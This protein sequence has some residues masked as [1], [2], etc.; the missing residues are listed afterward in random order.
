MKEG[1][2]A[3]KPSCFSEVT[4]E[5]ERDKVTVGCHVCDESIIWTFVLKKKKKRKKEGK[6]RIQVKLY[7]LNET[8]TLVFFF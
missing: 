2:I 8:T 1:C 5:Q 6:T 7:F 4:E 3:N